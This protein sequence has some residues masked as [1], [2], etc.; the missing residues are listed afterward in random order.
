MPMAI[1]KFFI[2]KLGKNN[3]DSVKEEI[4]VMI[5]NI[6]EAMMRRASDIEWLD[7]KTRQYIIEK[8]S[9]IKNRIAYPDEIMDSKKL[10]KQYE[11]LKIDNY[12][13]L[14]INTQ[15]YNFGNIISSHTT[16]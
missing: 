16:L 13:S 8:T 12:Y 14:L 11:N 2:E 6:K 10:Y 7:E 3:V 1:S 4:L 5:D 9:K 15:I